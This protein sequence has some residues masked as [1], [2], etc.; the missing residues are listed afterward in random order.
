MPSVPFMYEK[1]IAASVALRQIG[2]VLSRLQLSTMAPVLL[3]EPKLGRNPV[4]P[5]VC[6]GEMIDPHVS[7]PIAKGSSPAETAAAEPA[8]EPL[9]PFSRFQGFLVLPPN[10]RSAK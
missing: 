9:D 2:P 7:V 10:Q 3:M 6:E 5:Q 4:T 1:M 8:D